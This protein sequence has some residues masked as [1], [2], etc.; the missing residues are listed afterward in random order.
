MKRSNITTIIISIIVITICYFCL[1]NY[2]NYNAI[3]YGQKDTDLYQKLIF[4]V[5]EENDDIV[6]TIKYI[7]IDTNSF[8]IASEKEKQALAS[9][10]KKYSNNV[11][12]ASYS[13][14]QNMNLEDEQGPLEGIIISVKEIERYL[15][16]IK[17]QIIVY[18]NNKEVISYNFKA[19]YN[20]KWKIKYSK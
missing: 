16:Q 9:N 17:G 1:C 14:L 10:L 13:L 5:L 3:K 8:N 15:N 20:N 11:F 4:N 18:Q 12:L 2:K 6:S 7:A 19:T